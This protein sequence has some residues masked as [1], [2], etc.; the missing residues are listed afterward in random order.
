MNFL[1]VVENAT[2]TA[3]QLCNDVLNLAFFEIVA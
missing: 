3:E 1:G 2:I